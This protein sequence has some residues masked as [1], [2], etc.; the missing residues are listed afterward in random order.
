MPT[1]AKGGNSMVAIFPSSVVKVN[2]TGLEIDFDVVLVL[3]KYFFFFFE[4]SKST[5]NAYCS[6]QVCR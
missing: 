5:K 6:S 4:D 3:T 2:I 1:A